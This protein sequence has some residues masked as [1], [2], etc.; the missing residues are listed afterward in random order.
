VVD[1]TPRFEWWIPQ[2]KLDDRLTYVFCGNSYAGYGP[3]TC[4]RW[5][6]LF[7]KA[8]PTGMQPSFDL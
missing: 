7:G 8:V 5:L 3:G 4:E 6:N 2:L 1:A